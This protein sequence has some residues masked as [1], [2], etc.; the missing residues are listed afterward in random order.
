MSISFTPETPLITGYS[1]SGVKNIIVIASDGSASDTAVF[2]VHVLNSNRKPILVK[3]SDTLTTAISGMA[4]YTLSASDPDYDILR[5]WCKNGKTTIAS[6]TDSVFT[7]ASTVAGKDTLTLYATD[8]F[9][10]VS[11]I[12]TV[13]RPNTTPSERLIPVASFCENSQPNP[14]NPSTVIRY[15]LANAEHVYVDVRD[16]KGRQVAVLVDAKRQAGYFNVVWDA[17]KA[18]SGLY[19]IS[20]RLGKSY[21]KMIKTLLLK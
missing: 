14:F 16:I 18:P 2:S 1:D 13:Y 8:G 15:G 5:F 19:F 4:N 21:H 7:I 10:T 20:V 12:L 6:N 11:C 3:T 17:G 9:D